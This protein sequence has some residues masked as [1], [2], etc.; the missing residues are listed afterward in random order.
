VSTSPPPGRPPLPWDL[1]RLPEP[2]L[3][4]RYAELREWTEQLLAMGLE[5]P[6]CWYYHRHLV[7]RMAA[8]M[9][10]RERAYRTRTETADRPGGEVTVVP[11]AIAREAA[12]WWSA[13]WGL[14]GL[15]SAWA[16]LPCKAGRTH[17]IGSRSVETPSM[18]DVVDTH[19]AFLRALP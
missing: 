8:V 11:G 12:E 7:H 2:E 6:G 1:D 4:Q 9:A 13:S 15:L 5:V 17:T 14:A 16:D 3:R 18:E 19:I 10:A